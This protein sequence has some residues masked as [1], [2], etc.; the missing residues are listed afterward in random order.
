M[1]GANAFSSVGG[2]GFLANPSE[3]DVTVV[4]LMDR[5]KVCV[6]RSATWKEVVAEFVD[7]EHAEYFR[8][9]LK[10]NIK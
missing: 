6:R 3:D 5:S 7:A 8:K 4:T 9:Y 2:I 1:G 10:D